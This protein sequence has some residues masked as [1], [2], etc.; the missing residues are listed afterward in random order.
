MISVIVS[1]QQKEYAVMGKDEIR[2]WQTFR[3]Q[4][5][6]TGKFVTIVEVGG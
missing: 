3:A 2:K 5:F 4:G 1:S 6:R